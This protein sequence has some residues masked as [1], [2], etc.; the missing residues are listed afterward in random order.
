VTD[1]NPLSILDEHLGELEDR[2]TRVQSNL[3]EA[4]ATIKYGSK[5]V[6][7][8]PSL[9]GAGI[10]V[11][12]ILPVSE[13]QTLRL[14]NRVTKMLDKDEQSIVPMDD[15]YEIAEY[16]KGYRFGVFFH[17]QNTVGYTNRYHISRL[18][19]ISDEEYAKARADDCDLE[20]IRDH[21]W[22]RELN[23]VIISA[24][25]RRPESPRRGHCE[26]CQSA[27]LML[28]KYYEGKLSLQF[29]TLPDPDDPDRIQLRTTHGYEDDWQGDTLRY[30]ITCLDCKHETA[31]LDTENKYLETHACNSGKS[32]IEALFD[33]GDDQFL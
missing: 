2:V 12:E 10:V 17:E 14:V 24:I 33:L 5:V 26:K 31:P 16:E 6:L 22:F 18:F 11:G 15:A 13:Y 32:V 20:K 7:L 28:N 29:A 23:D 4:Q 1:D 30:T 19:P 9:V 8:T 25:E 3:D 21:Q 27:N